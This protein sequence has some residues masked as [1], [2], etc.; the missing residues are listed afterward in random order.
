MSQKESKSPVKDLKTI[1]AEAGLKVLA[2]EDDPI[3]QKLI[4]LYLK[5]SGCK[6]V[7]VSNGKQVLQKLEEQPF[8][9]VL[10]DCSMPVMDGFEASRQIR[11]HPDFSKIRIIAL[12]AHS[13]KGIGNVV[14][15]LEWMIIYLNR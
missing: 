14:L 8:D 10:M 5:K 3:N 7:I 12:T 13:L 15:P 9:L 2:A 1:L 11:K 4:K 6:A